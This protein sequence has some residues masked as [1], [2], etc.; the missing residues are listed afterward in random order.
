MIFDRFHKPSFAACENGTNLEIDFHQSSLSGIRLREEVFLPVSEWSGTGSPGC[1][2][3]PVQDRH[4]PAA[5]TGD[6]T[7]SMSLPF[8]QEQWE[9]AGEDRPGSRK[10]DLIAL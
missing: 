6:N 5:V 10:T 2:G 4:G 9:D 3:K 7:S 8:I 1:L